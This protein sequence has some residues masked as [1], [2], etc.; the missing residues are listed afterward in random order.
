M[1]VEG[2]FGLQTP[3]LQPRTQLAAK[4]RHKDGER[5]KR[6]NQKKVISVVFCCFLSA[7]CPASPAAAP[8]LLHSVQVKESSP[9][10]HHP[11]SRGFPERTSSTSPAANVGISSET[12]GWENFHK[13][14]QKKQKAKK[15]KKTK[16][17]LG[18]L[19]FSSRFHVLSSR[20][21][22]SPPSPLR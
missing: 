7:G 22:P 9:P 5:D 14:P 6:R 17:P 15:A 19:S 12:P 3:K 2:G 11:S 8:L 13:E 1:E 4:S 21:P 20:P 10:P 16:P 18:L